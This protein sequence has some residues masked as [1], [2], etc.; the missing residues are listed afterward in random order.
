MRASGGYEAEELTVRHCCRDAEEAARLR[1]DHAGSTELL[2]EDGYISVRE[3]R[4]KVGCL[5]SKAVISVQGR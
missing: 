4:W 3:G 1:R 5:H 2:T